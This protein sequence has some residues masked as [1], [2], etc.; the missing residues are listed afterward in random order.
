[1][2]PV[3]T[4]IPV[5]SDALRA[6]IGKTA[7]EVV[8]PPRYL[9]LVDAVEGYYGVRTP[10]ADTLNEYFHTFRNVD[11]LIDG[12]Q[13]ILLRNWSYFERSEDRMRLFTLLSELVLGLLETPLTTQQTSLLLRQLIT[14]STSALSGPHAEA[15]DEPLLKIARILEHELPLRPFA[16]L[17]RDTLIH[18]LVQA[19]AKRPALQKAFSVLYRS[20]LLLGYRLLAER[21]P[22]PA[23]ATS[24]DAELTNKQTVAARF[25]DLAPAAMARLIEQ[26]E[27]APNDKLLSSELPPF[28]TILDRAIDQ[29]FRI[30]DIEDRFAVCLYF[31]KDDTL[32]YRQNEVM[33]DL[34]GVVRQLMAPERPLDVDTILAR[35][36]R[37]FRQRDNQFL[38][39]RFQ[40]YEAIGVAIGQAGNVAAA[41]HLIEDVLSWKFQYPEIEGT[42]GRRWSTPSISPRSAAGCTSSNPTP[43][44]TSAWPQ[45]S[46]CNSGWAVC[47]SPTPTCSSAMSPA[48]ST[49]TSGPSTS[50]PNNC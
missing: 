14:W 44:C 37:F 41:D 47:T 3:D 29:V 23:W 46:T 28:S 36:T 17:E 25:A 13:T 34:L 15:Y 20:L 4:K 1:M 12:F 21:L 45:P 18:N 42:S 43:P 49:L 33:V 35:L 22:L 27:S 24:A 48:S 38:L 50:S 6:N 31:L 19:A 8:I 11:L 16:F 32:G 30:D 2:E 5:D 10:L 26:A 9:P 39:M 7:Q 40:C